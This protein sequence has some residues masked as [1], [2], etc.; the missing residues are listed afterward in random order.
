[1][2]VRRLALRELRTLRVGLR[3]EPDEF[4]DAGDIVV[5]AAVRD[6]AKGAAIEI[7]I[8]Y[9]ALSGHSRWQGDLRISVID[10]GRMP[11]KPWGCRS[12]TLTPTPEP[13]GYCAGDVAGERGD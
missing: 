4:I 10:S 12:K 3:V 11:S 9:F 7:E 6:Q 2:Q 13:A 5:V 8:G 1:M